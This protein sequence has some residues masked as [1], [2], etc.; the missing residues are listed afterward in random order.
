MNRRLALSCSNLAIRDLVLHVT[1]TTMFLPFA[2]VSQ[3]LRTP[4]AV[5]HDWIRSGLALAGE[6]LGG[7]SSAAQYGKGRT[8]VLP[9]LD[10]AQTAMDLAKH[11]VDRVNLLPDRRVA[12]DQLLVKAL[13]E[14]SVMAKILEPNNLEHMISCSNELCA[15]VLASGWLTRNEIKI[16]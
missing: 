7:R 6:V 12:K 10:V 2:A 5:Q 3:V 16:G 13:L 4:P 8:C 9:T 14:F 15:Q 11:D 1:P